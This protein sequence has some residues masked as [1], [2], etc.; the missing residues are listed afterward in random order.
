MNTKS[1]FIVQ[2]IT[3]NILG[4]AGFGEYLSEAIFFPTK[5]AALATSLRYAGSRITMIDV[6]TVYFEQ[7]LSRDSDFVRVGWN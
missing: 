4:H 3:G 7:D 1:C 5:Q 6:P 2:D